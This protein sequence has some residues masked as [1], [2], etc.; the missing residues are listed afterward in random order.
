VISVGW[1]SSAEGPSNI[2]GRRPEQERTRVA[3]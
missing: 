2:V 1:R 3:I